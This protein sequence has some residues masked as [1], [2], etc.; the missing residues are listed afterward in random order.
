MDLLILSLLVYL[1]TYEDPK[2]VSNVV[3]TVITNNN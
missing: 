2:N 3:R 1:A